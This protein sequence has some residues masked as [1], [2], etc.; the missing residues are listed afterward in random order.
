MKVTNIFNTNI[1]TR[2]RFVL[3]TEYH[4]LNHLGLIV[5]TVGFVKES[6][7][8]QL[9]Y[10]YLGSTGVRRARNFGGA[11]GSARVKVRLG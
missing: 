8:V 2:L 6:Q 10:V 5:G 3:N 4:I 9:Q 1:L 11:R 7:H